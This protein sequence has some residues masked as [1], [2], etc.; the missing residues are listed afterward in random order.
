MPRMPRIKL[1]VRVEREL[2]LHLWMKKRSRELLRCQRAVDS[3]PA[4]VHVVENR[5][6]GLDGQ[7]GVGK[8]RPCRLIVRLDRRPILSQRKLQPDEP[9]HMAVR[10]MVNDLPHGPTAWPV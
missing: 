8:A 4:C 3:L 6:R 1:H 9:V 7:R 5:E 10:D 2:L